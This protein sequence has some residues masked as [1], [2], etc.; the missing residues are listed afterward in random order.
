MLILYILYW[1]TIYYID[2]PPQLSTGI[3]FVI[4]PDFHN[5]IIGRIFQS[6]AT[7]K[8]CY[9]SNSILNEYSS[10]CNFQYIG[11]LYTHSS[12]I[13]KIWH[14]SKEFDA[15]SNQSPIENINACSAQSFSRILKTSAT[16]GLEIKW[17]SGLFKP[18]TFV[19]R[20]NR[21][22]FEIS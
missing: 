19:W 2:I 5:Y 22:T 12:S 14:S 18:Q 16:A 17:K 1:Y 15:S 21:K 8:V 6:E 10:S 11:T 9:P 3:I 13:L 7:V 4:E 20:L